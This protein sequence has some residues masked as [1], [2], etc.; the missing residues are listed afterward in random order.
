MTKKAQSRRTDPL[1]RDGDGDPG[2]SL[3]GNKTAPYMQGADAP[4]DTATEAR[5]PDANP[6]GAPNRP[7]DGPPNSDAE[8]PADPPADAPAEQAAQDPQPWTRDDALIILKLADAGL[9][10]DPAHI[11]SLTEEAVKA[12]SDEDA[13]AAERW[14]D[15]MT[16]DGAHFNDE[17]GAW[18]TGD[19]ETIERPEVVARHEAWTEEQLSATKSALA[20]AFQRIDAAT[21][22][23]A[24]TFTPEEIAAAKRGVAGEDGETVDQPDAVKED[25]A[26]IQTDEAPVAVRI[27]ELKALLDHRRLYRTEDGYSATQHPPFISNETVEAWKRAGLCEDVPSAGRMGGVKPTAKARQQFNQLAAEHGGR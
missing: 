9:D 6:D 17:Q 16:A 14:A 21:S 15:Q 10:I 25:L 5:A 19:L 8:P 18:V 7:D 27:R 20:E 11:G 4:A 13:Q 1:D 12:W 22:E 3:P 23:T 26:V 2:G 24:P